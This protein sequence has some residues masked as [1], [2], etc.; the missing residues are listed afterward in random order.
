MKQILILFIASLILLLSSFTDNNKENYNLT[1]E[2]ENL[3]N[4]KGIVQ[5]TLYNKDGS[6]PDEHYKNYHKI[7]KATIKNGK[8]ECTF[9]NLPQGNYALNI[10][11][12]ENN[13]GKVDKGLVLPKEGIGFSNYLSIGLSNRPSFKKASFELNQNKT[14]KVKVI[15]M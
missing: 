11:H 12:D 3:R 14:V 7:E 10:L 8:A 15:Y 4:S 1:V 13:N 2:I 5:I 6:I 9:S